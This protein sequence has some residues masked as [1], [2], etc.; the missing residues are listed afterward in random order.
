MFQGFPERVVWALVALTTEELA[1]VRY[2]AWD[3]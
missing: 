2:I 3:C 1:D